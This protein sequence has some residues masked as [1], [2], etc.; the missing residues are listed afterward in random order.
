MLSRSGSE[1][2]KEEPKFFFE[3]D[4]PFSANFLFDKFPPFDF[5]GGD[6]SDVD[7]DQMTARLDLGVKGETGDDDGDIDKA[8]RS[9][10][11]RING[12]D[13]RTPFMYENVSEVILDP[14]TGEANEV[15]VYIFDGGSN[16]VENNMQTSASTLRFAA[17]RLDTGA[18]PRVRQ[19]RRSRFGTAAVSRRSG[20]DIVASAYD[21]SKPADSGYLTSKPGTGVAAGGYA[22]GEKEQKQTGQQQSQQPKMF[23]DFPSYEATASVTTATFAE[24]SAQ[25][26]NN[27]HWDQ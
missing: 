19:R 27:P 11:F 9:F 18:R 4:F 22:Y 15:V 10:F 24:Q 8:T 12:P 7:K 23:T 20:E 21:Y 2:L 13:G 5:F 16:K 6:K 26:G 1:P 17:R 14:I 25:K 3:E